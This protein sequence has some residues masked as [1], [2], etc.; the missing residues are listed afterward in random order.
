[1]QNGRN[2]RP[3]DDLFLY[4]GNVGIFAAGR[5]VGAEPAPSGSGWVISWQ[6]DGRRTKRL[7]DAPVAAEKVRNHV[8]PRVTVRDFN[9]GA[10]ALRRALA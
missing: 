2:V 9:K 1:V 10:K 3:G 6:L 5:V 4:T 7:L 8:H